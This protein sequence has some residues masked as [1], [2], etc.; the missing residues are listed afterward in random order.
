M[1]GPVQGLLLLLFPPVAA[2]VVVVMHLVRGHALQG[3]LIEV[4]GVRTL[5]GQRGDGA[6][7]GA[8]VRDGLR[9]T[10][11]MEQGQGTSTSPCSAAQ[12]PVR[13][14]FYSDRQGQGGA[15]EKQLIGS[16]WNGQKNLE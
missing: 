4:H 8:C 2:V 1:C 6:L 9:G 3:V 14:G 10:G 16:N 7:H 5:R 15:G 12:Y 13:G 11:D